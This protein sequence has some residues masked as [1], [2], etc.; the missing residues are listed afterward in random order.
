MLPGRTDPENQGG[1][2]HL[3][4]LRFL[5][6]DSVPS[7]EGG[8]PGQ[9]NTHHFRQPQGR[10]KQIGDEGSG[11]LCGEYFQAPMAH[12]HRTALNKIGCK[13]STIGWIGIS[14]GHK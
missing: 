10:Q 9:G 2:R 8:C 1:Q 11:R 6:G 4:G 5:R 3:A 14:Q 7:P 12:P 13:K